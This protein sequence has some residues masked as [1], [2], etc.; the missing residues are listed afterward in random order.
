MTQ[1]TQEFNGSIANHLLMRLLDQSQAA[2]LQLT[3]IEGRL[4]AGDTRM[5]Q[6][7]TMQSRT[8]SDMTRRVAALER[9][10]DRQESGAA[11]VP[12]LELRVKWALRYLILIGTL[13]GTGS[14]DA[15]VKLFEALR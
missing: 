8:I 2:A 7:E 1:E 12:R 11:H 13:W 4:V 15:A 5:D 6:I 3:R 9:R 10:Q 14:V